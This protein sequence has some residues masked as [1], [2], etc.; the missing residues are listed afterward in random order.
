LRKLFL[1]PFGAHDATERVL[2]AAL[3]TGVESAEIL[4][5]CPSPRKQRLVQVQFFRL[6]NR[7]AIVPP[8]FKTPSQV[9]RDLHEQFG[10]AR[11]FTS[12]LKPLLLQR[13]LSQE[14]PNQKPDRLSPLASRLSP[15]PSIGY[16]RAV[17]DFIA[18]I[19]RYVPRSEQA[20]LKGRF[21]ELL[22][23]YEKP[24]ARALEALEA[25]ELYNRELASRN[26]ADDEDIMAEAALHVGQNRACP[27]VLVL[28]S[29][30]APNRLEAD[31]M[32]A[33]IAQAET[34]V[35]LGYAGEPR[36]E[37]YRLA[38]KFVELVRSQ[39]G[40][41]IETLPASPAPPE[42]QLFAFPT[43][44]D[45]VAGICRDINGR[46]AG[47]T[48][49][50]IVVA[51][52][53]LADYAAL[54]KR[55][56]EQY[57]LPVT[58]Y[59]TTDLAASPPVLAVLEL[60]RA[61]DS[62]YERI[63][64][65]AALGSPYL[66]GLL[67]LKADSDAADRDRAAV[68]LN[69]YSRR[70]RIIKGRVNWNNI[71]A[72]LESAEDRLDETELEYINGLQKR[73]RQATGLVE[74]MLEP[75]DTIGNQARR[76]KQFLEAVD[77]CRNL[78]ADEPGTDELL[79][80]RSALYDILDA[81]SDF[82]ADFGA[83][84]ESRTQFIKTL[85]YL[86]RLAG[87]APEPAPAGVIVMDMTET[88]G[89]TPKHLYFGGLTETNLPGA[90]SGDPILPDRVRRE[91]GMPDID[92]HRDWQRFS[93]CRTMSASPNTPFLSFYDSDEGRP[94]LASPFL[95]ITSLKPV[96]S[97]AIYSK[98]EEQV[99]QGRAAGVR[100]AD[101]CRPVDF[102]RDP[103]VLKALAARFGPERPISVTR[104]EAYRTCPYLFYL[105][106]ILGLETP[107]EPRYDIDS[108]QWGLVV[109][110]VMEKLYA[111]GSVPVEQVHDAAMKAL[112]ATLAE[113]ELPVFWQ[114]VTR[115]VFAN[116]LP[117]LVRCE[118]E[119]REGG[120]HP[121]K[122]EVSL[123][124]DLAKDIAVRGR[125]DRVDASATAF[126]VLDYKTGRP[127]NFT[128]KAVVDGTHVQLPLY[129]WLYQQGK[130]GLAI[131]NFGVYALREPEV[132][133]F[134][135]RKYT[136]DELVKAALANAVAIVKSIRKGEFPA[137]PADDR[138]CEYCNLGHTCGL[139]ETEKDS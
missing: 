77:Y 88:L 40:F 61:L 97:E 134:S 126:R 46:G 127:G 90:Y 10:T 20:S 139:R 2:K 109:H 80:D 63:A 121:Q 71:A 54:V 69:H 29:F 17:G 132:I 98:A 70:A 135:R 19:K 74:K 8:Q 28:D 72:R 120:F 102:G 60:L 5:L 64:T 108:R 22:A 42:P 123:N 23:A 6:V 81:L 65:A 138:V 114:E 47:I 35:A 107:E 58:V 91:L 129:A 105:E 111:R 56:F 50:D 31:I 101:T 116:L 125:F 49:T 84:K 137:L 110:R 7:P 26:W 119:L 38:S 51:F 94:V 59:P 16:A 27:R 131:D 87:R 12:E 82:E 73:I 79:E 83:R 118:A 34:C 85:V 92:W 3:E 57:E 9:A 122:P 32:S 113:V 53:R 25:L 14:T 124:G 76:L 68:A 48:L 15:L 78:R 93:F 1:A 89:L 4:Y 136:V 103:D 115:R 21:K 44:E 37:D 106:N 11:R 100:F 24:L 128:P 130:P 112:D 86:I 30:I 33:L 36:D 96:P 52:P 62:D 133:W 95:T 18:E 75:A 43:I 45:E 66:P 13:L 104:L 39:E 67:N 41:T 55:M 117:D 99:A